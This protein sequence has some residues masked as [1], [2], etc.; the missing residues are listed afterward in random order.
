MAMT[1][2]RIKVEAIA[3]A[4]A[5]RQAAAARRAT[6]TAV[7]IEHGLE[8]SV[9]P[10]GTARPYKIDQPQ[11]SH[12]GKACQHVKAVKPEDRLAMELVPLLI[13]WIRL[14]T[15]H[16]HVH[17]LGEITGAKNKDGPEKDG[18]KVVKKCTL[19]DGGPPRPIEIVFVLAGATPVVGVI[20]GRLY[21][22][23]IEA[24]QMYVRHLTRAFAGMDQGV[25]G[26]S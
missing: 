26:V 17:G 20:K 1:K 21:A 3:T 9:E 7:A 12:D 11:N 6:V 16:V 15:E 22:P 10:R 18:Q 24:F 14:V 19:E 8:S 2:G 25:L 23:S 5:A 13:G 4:V